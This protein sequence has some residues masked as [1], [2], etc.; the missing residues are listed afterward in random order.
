VTEPPNRTP[1]RVQ[2]VPARPEVLDSLVDCHI[3]AAPT[4]I[5]PLLGRKFLKV[6]D[7]YYIQQP[8]GVC[9]VTVDEQS[10]RVSGYVL[11]GDPGIR[12]RFVATHLLL[13]AKTCFAR[14]F[15]C[16]E[17]SWR[18]IAMVRS[19]AVGTV[20]LLRG[21]RDGHPSSLYHDPPGSWAVSLSLGTHP[22]F[23]KD[24]AA[25]A[26]A[27]LS[28]IRTQCALLGYQF[29]HN[30]VS[31]DNTGS[32]LLHQRLGFQLVG[33]VGEFHWYRVETQTGSSSTNRL[34]DVKE[35][36]KFIR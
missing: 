1:D 34:S 22:E 36:D 5:L 14:F 3:A 2:A 15:H 10:G 12:G 32:N 35:A 33:T 8:A 20:R 7:L 21:R 25:R 27:L 26:I 11:G 16:R 6:H 24:G 23:R 9:L 4:D 17:F 19:T 28:G 13:V 30:C 31:T 29:I 18:I